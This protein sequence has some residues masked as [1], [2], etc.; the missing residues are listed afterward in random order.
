MEN[1]SNNYYRPLSQM[2]TSLHDYVADGA[3]KEQDEEEN[4][5]EQNDG[6]NFTEEEIKKIF[7]INYSRLYWI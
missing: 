3:E 5:K 2:S 1:H 7:S 6:D 4:K